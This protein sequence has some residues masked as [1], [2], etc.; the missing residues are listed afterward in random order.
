MQSRYCLLFGALLGMLAVLLGAFGAHGLEKMVDAKMLQR[1]NTGV[2]YQ[3][4][5]ALSLLFVGLFMRHHASRWLGYAAY[6][7][8]MGVLL[9]S[10]GL[11]SYVLTAN[12]SFAMITPI[13]GITLI[14]GWLLLLSS[15]WQY[16]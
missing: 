16:K 12:P 2:E 15:I 14:I 6:A 9:F 7:F 1:F 11:Y 3:F 8:L 5:H 10:G 4:Y 13:G